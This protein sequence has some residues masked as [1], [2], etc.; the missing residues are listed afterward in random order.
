MALDLKSLHLDPNIMARNGISLGANHN[1]MPYLDTST[2]TQGA[3]HPQAPAMS[4]PLVM[5]GV[6]SAG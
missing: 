4:Q 2:Q 5:G 3:A 1:A 6:E